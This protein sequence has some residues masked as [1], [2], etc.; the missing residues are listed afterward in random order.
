MSAGAL[1]FDTSNIVSAKAARLFVDEGYAFALRYVPRVTHHPSDVTAEELRALKAAGLGVMLVQ[2]CE[3]PGWIPSAQKGVAYGDMA[4]AEADRVGLAKGTTV[5]LDLEG[6]AATVPSPITIAYCNAWHDRVASLGYTPGLYVGDHCGLTASELYWR[7][8][9]RGYWGAYNLDRDR[10]PLVRGLQMKQREARSDDIPL[11]C[12]VVI[13][14]D[15]VSGDALGGLPM[16]DFSPT[17][18]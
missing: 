11:G 1:G 18:A 14:V 8:K 16:M 3:M 6:V 4:G 2:H 9:F 5:W 15:V 12:G 13:D 10:F 17:M 7:L